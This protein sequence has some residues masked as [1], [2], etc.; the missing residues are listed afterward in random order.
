[1]L[2]NE[3]GCKKWSNNLELF[4]EGGAGAEPSQKEY[5]MALITESPMP[6]ATVAN[7]HIDPPRD[8][9]GTVRVL[10]IKTEIAPLP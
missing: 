5:F 10:R 7:L 8:S 6:K 3:E 2:L 1:M 4:C 9:F